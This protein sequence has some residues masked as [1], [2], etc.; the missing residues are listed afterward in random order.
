MRHDEDA[1]ERFAAL[2]RACYGRLVAQLYAITSDL[3]EAQE[4]VQEAFVRAWSRWPELQ[5]FDNPEGWL[6]VVAQRIA[7]SRW[8]R[9]RRTVL[10]WLRENDISHYSGPDPS[11][12]VLVEALRR[13]PVAQRRA[14]VLHHMGDRSVAEIAEVEG[15]PAG[16]VKARLSR[17]RAALAALLADQPVGGTSVDRS[18]AERSSEEVRRAYRES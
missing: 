13:L 14:L 6:Y 4:A 15:V 1:E 7:V 9:T 2:Y 11:V 3:G 8:R 10:G 16:T 5:T 17:G 12:V 18:G